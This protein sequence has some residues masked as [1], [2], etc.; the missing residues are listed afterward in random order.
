MSSLREYFGR[1]IGGLQMYRRHTY[2]GHPLTRRIMYAGT[3]KIFRISRD[4]L[5]LGHKDHCEVLLCVLI[6]VR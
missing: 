5:S 1:S 2:P 4:V 3:Q 6:L